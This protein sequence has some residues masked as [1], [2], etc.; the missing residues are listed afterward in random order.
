MNCARYILNTRICHLFSASVESPAWWHR[1]LVALHAGCGHGGTGWWLIGFQ[2]TLL[3]AAFPSVTPDISKS[4]GHRGLRRADQLP[5]W[6]PKANSRWQLPVPCS[7]SFH[8]SF[9]VVYHTSIGTPH[10]PTALNI[11]LVLHAYD[12]FKCSAIIWDIP[13]E[14]EEINE[15]VLAAIINLM[16][17]ATC[18]SNCWALDSFLLWL[19]SDQPSSLN[20]GYCID[21]VHLEVSAMCLCVHICI[22]GTTNPHICASILIFS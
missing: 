3:F 10:L 22:L 16:P 7:G 11:C 1:C 5:L 8:S 4:P 17:C 19:G 18:F 15:C 2:W 6:W 9:S 12:F 13:R 21:K 20:Q 14:E